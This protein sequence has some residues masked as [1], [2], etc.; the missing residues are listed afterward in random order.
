MVFVADM[1]E[2][3]ADTADTAAGMGMAAY[4]SPWAGT[5]TVPPFH[6]TRL[7]TTIIPHTRFGIIRER[8]LMIGTTVRG[9]TAGTGE[10]DRGCYPITSLGRSFLPDG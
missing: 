4:R 3:M 7:P 10:P 5:A 1:V 2:A 9:I 6:I 8:V